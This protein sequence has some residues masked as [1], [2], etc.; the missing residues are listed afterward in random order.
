MFQNMAMGNGG[1]SGQGT[2]LSSN[3]TY[4]V[5]SHMDHNKSIQMTVTTVENGYVI[6][7]RDLM[8]HSARS[9]IRV[10]LEGCNL[11]EE[12]AAVIASHQL[13]G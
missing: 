11:S 1:I 6:E 13:K 10:A 7:I 8:D 12:I 3:S 4:T 2:I 5:K 9:K